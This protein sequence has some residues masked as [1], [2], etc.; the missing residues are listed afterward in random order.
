MLIPFDSDYCDLCPFIGVGC[1][2]C[3]HDKIKVYIALDPDGC[4][5]IEETELIYE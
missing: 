1:E 5:I 2:D 3:K 4:A